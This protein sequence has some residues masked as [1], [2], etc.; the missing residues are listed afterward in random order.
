[1]LIMKKL[2][3]LLSNFHRP[4]CDSYIL[5]YDIVFS[6]QDWFTTEDLFTDLSFFNIYPGEDF[7][8]LYGDE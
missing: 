1:M 4:I 8:K 3:I 5:W 2:K 6:N 7:F